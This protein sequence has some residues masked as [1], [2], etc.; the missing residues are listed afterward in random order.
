M[1][2]TRLVIGHVSRSK[3]TAVV[4]V[5]EMRAAGTDTEE[6]RAWLCVAARYGVISAMPDETNVSLA[7]RGSGVSLKRQ[8][9]KAPGCGSALPHATR[10]AHG[11][12]ASRIEIGN[13]DH[14]HQRLAAGR[15]SDHMMDRPSAATRSSSTP[16]AWP[17]CQRSL[18]AQFF[19]AIASRFP[20]SGNL[21]VCFRFFTPQW[22]LVRAL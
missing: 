20:P 14:G 9:S 6:N 10:G 3:K 18:R 15:C 5:P 13:P 1:F 21:S 19:D 11:R 7:R 2:S 12:R 8:L 4:Q 22:H 17:V 16:F